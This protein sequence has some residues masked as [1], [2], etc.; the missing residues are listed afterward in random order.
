[1]KATKKNEIT[2]HV[3][4]AKPANDC[5]SLEMA[6]TGGW[7][8][9]A[10]FWPLKNLI[11]VNPI[12][13][14]EDLSFEEGLKQAQAYFQQKDI[15][16]GM[17]HVNRESIKWLQAFFDQGQSTIHM[18]N[19]HLGFLKS[20]LSLIK[21]DERLHKNDPQKL[22]WLKKL[23]QKPEMV[24]AE[25]L[26][27]LGIP[28]QVQEQFL[29]LMLTTLPGW[30]AHIQY[31]TSWADAEDVANPHTVTRSEYL[32][33]RLV[34]TCLVW[35]EAKVLIAWHQN[36]LKE[37]DVKAI[38]DEVAANEAAYQSDLLKQVKQMKQSKQTSRSK[39][40]LIF[41][42]D[43]RSEP[44][45][46]ALEA[47]GD[48]ETYG[49]A[50]FF[51]VP[52]AIENAV[53]GESHA[54]CPVLL[55]PAH[56]IVERPNRSHQSYQRRYSRIQGVK[57]L[58][59]S[60]KYT[61]TT[62][63]SLVE[64]IGIGSGLWMALRSLSPNTATKIQ[65]ALK[66]TIGSNYSLTPDIQ[67]IPLDQQVAYGAGVLKMMGLTENF[68]PLV[69]LCG[70]GSTTQNNAYA[71]A[72]DCG[73]CGGRHGAPNARILAAI[74]NA[75]EIRQALIKRGIVIPADTLFVAAEH[76]TTTD[77]VKIY[78]DDL[79][80]EK[81]KEIAALK[82]DLEKSRDENSLWRAHEMGVHTKK[83]RAQKATALRSQD[84]AQVRPEWGLARNAAFIVAPRSLTKDI[85][86]E[87][88]SFLHSYEWEKD[89]DGS[90]LTTILTAPMVVAQWINSQ[91]LL[92][93]LDNVAFGGGSK[94]TKNIT[95]KIGIMQGN[96]SD[97]M[98]GLP[99]QSVYKS[100]KEAYHKPM[101]LTVIVYAPKL[102]IDPIIKQQAILQKLFSNGWVRLICHDPVEKQ[103]FSLQRDL[104]WAKMQ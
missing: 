75:Q 46:R 93:T 22:Q 102:H 30:A 53:T 92:S 58:Y 87:G 43:V 73:A 63:F 5:H 28:T 40:Q 26:L 51:G 77:E 14:F 96:A 11:A 52:V 19:R 35:P 47:Q 15:P 1:M 48:Y 44:F 13:G 12:A 64:A 99:L 71:T 23:P 79:S 85:N 100:D 69:V 98:H 32:A 21:F 17:K 24:I 10:P 49:F 89:E 38:Y 84:W 103:K 82:Q 57:K 54:S 20:T 16:E 55:K 70:H 27:N 39:A 6:I 8:K 2:E 94:I 86:L 62:P 29:T 59:Q 41:C 80:E 74:L 34:L 90:S 101:R 18:P 104:A 76:N 37:S 83:N 36:A 9:I 88:R 33:F 91:Y 81:A 78:T 61:F 68:A 67:A 45:R 25:A 60:L 56:D 42:I 97:L 31:R 4:P 50:G 66:S 7:S 65:S 72:L 3:T 95:G